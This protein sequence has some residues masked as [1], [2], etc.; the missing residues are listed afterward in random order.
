MVFCTSSFFLGLA[1]VF[2]ILVF[3]NTFSNQGASSFIS[4]YVSIFLSHRCFC[5]PTE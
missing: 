3:W 2:Y 5:W 1:Q 4:A